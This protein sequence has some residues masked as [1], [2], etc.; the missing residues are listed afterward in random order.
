MA[1]IVPFDPRLQL[2]LPVDNPREM[3]APHMRLVSSCEQGGDMERS[4]G[5]PDRHPRWCVVDHGREGAPSRH[6]GAGRAV[7]VL[8]WDAIAGEPSAPTAR[9]LVAVLHSH[10]EGGDRWLYVGDGR[11]QHLDLSGESWQLVIA[12]VLESLALED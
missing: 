5:D 4:D 9:E 1:S 3:S 11:G 7:D 2:R 6:Q 8:V 12:A 10:G